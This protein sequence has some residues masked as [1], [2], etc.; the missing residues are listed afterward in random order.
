MILMG[1]KIMTKKI[2]TIS[3][4]VLAA[5]IVAVV[6]FTYVPKQIKDTF[7]VCTV[8]GETAELDIIIQYYSSL[9][10]PSYVKGTI[11]FNGV[12]YTDQYTALKEYKNVSN[13]QLFPSDWWKRNSSTPYN[14]TFVRSDCTD[15]I[16]ASL[17]RIDIWN[18]IFDEGVSKILCT[19]T[20]EANKIDE[21]IRGISYW[22]PAQNAEEAKQ[23]AE[24]LGY[25]A[26]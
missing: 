9:I 8:T 25:A 24:S 15:A 17:N 26:P 10:L 21:S 23:I 3:I 20:D 22:G 5:I 7:T 1:E 13:N 12:V 4:I 6:L 14:T 2:K 18:I 19:Y 11:A 16:S